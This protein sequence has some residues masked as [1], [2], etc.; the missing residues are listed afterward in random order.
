VAAVVIR[1]TRAG[2]HAPSDLLE[3]LAWVL[4]FDE[5]VVHRPANPSALHVLSGW[6]D[7]KLFV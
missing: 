1:G 7:W 3:L 4:A 5:K 6:A 2:R